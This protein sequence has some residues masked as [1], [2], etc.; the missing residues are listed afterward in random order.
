MWKERSNN[1]IYPPHEYIRNWFLWWWNVEANIHNR[2]WL[3]LQSKPFFHNSFSLNFYY[4]QYLLKLFQPT[5]RR[6]AT[7]QTQSHFSS[8]TETPTAQPVM[9]IC[10][11]PFFKL[12]SNLTLMCFNDNP[13]LLLFL[14]IKNCLKLWKMWYQ[15]FKIQQ[16]YFF[17]CVFKSD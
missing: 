2:S 11:V 3:A 16:T 10:G 15:F 4:I 13:H 7:S 6:I 12:R 14:N 8:M 17:L 5:L 9:F 1:P